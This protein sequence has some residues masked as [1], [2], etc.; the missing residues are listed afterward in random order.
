MSAREN[1]CAEAYAKD[2]N[3]PLEFGNANGDGSVVMVMVMVM[4]KRNI[5]ID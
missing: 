4:V 2:F 5:A 1:E 3:R